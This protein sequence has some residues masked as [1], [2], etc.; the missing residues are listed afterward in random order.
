MRLAGLVISVLAL[1]SG[2]GAEPPADAAKTEAARELV[3][4]NGGDP[5]SLDPALA[6]DL[7]AYAVLADLYEGLLV[8][9]ADGGI[10]PGVAER[11]VVS[12][13]GLE[14]QFFL[15]EDAHW[16]DGQ[17]VTA[18]HFVHAL[19]HV[20]DPASGSPNAF[21]LE[22][23]ANAAEVLRG[24]LPPESLGVQADGDGI[25][26][27]RLARPAPWLPTI[28]AMS[29]ALPRRPD[30]HD[31]P[32]SFTTPGK[33]IGNGPYRLASLRPGGE[34]RLVR[35]EGF[36]DAES[37]AIQA[38]RYLP[39]TDPVAEL[40]LYRSGELDIT[41]TIPPSHFES[42]RVERSCELHVSPGLG[43]YYLAFDVT[44]PPLDDVRLRE[45]LSLAIDRRRLVAMLGR[46][47]AAAYGLV[48]PSIAS[49]EPDDPQWRSLDRAARERRARDAWAAAGSRPES[50]E[51]SYD[52]GDVHRQ[53]ALAVRSMWQEVLG[54]EV[55]LR[56]LEWKAFLDQRTD[57]DAWQVMRFVWVGDYDD[58]SSF[59]DLFTSAGD[60]NLPGY[61]NP[62]YDALVEQAAT[63]ADAGARTRLLAQAERLLLDDHPVA[64]LYFMTNKHLVAPRVTGFR[65]NPLDR[66]PSRW[67]RLDGVS[68]RSGSCAAAH[69]GSDDGAS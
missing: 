41:A 10:A 55:T 50:L 51:L 68:P 36:H 12:E 24:E 44:Q 4:G 1:A 64:P 37:V 47:E 46:G 30:V 28:L 8:A 3:R 21:L 38:V 19:R 52:S 42:L 69:C 45:A 60:N 56:Q 54:V 57:R 13:D 15:R 29:I 23:I 63:T 25:V 7:H 53:V 17:R 39:I 43:F 66:H 62:R 31:D 2:C 26:Q 49:H 48:P 27:I 9:D 35:D 34:I 16:S 61:G 6:E 11:W 14:W 67:L 18:A 65:Q 32:A 22:L 59:T 40:N 58:A 20:L 5:G 33:F